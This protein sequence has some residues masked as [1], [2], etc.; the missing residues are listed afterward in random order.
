MRVARLHGAGDLRVGDEPAP[1]SDAVRSY[2]AGTADDHCRVRILSAGLC[3]SDLHWFTEGA[4]G[5]AVLAR[6]LVPGHELSGLVLDG[7]LAGAVVGI[8][9]AVPC[10]QC[11]VCRRGAG[12][13]CPDVAFAGHGGVDGGLQE[14]LVWPLAQLHRL[15]DGFGAAEGAL[16]EPLGVAVHALDLSHL[17]A[18]CGVGVIGC[19]PIGLMLVQLAVAAGAQVA[20]VEPLAHRREAARRAGAVVVLQPQ[21]LSR[22][23][24]DGCEVVFEVSG[25]DGGVAAAGALVAPGGRIVLVGIPDG[26]RTTLRASP[27]R[28]KGA[29]LAFVRRMTEDAYRRG[30]GLA[31]DRVVDLSWLT[32]HRFPLEQAAEAFAVAVAREGLK[33]VVDVTPSGLAAGAMPVIG[34]SE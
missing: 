26:D 25:S 19:G 1:C 28:R 11:P 7:P 34:R 30:I 4:I 13:L 12:H 21:E 29:T 22:G 17:R 27:F 31:G 15:P 10:G 9:P 23:P 33:V 14:E 2:P 24:L 8:D 6:P 18:G 16:L 32:T 5:D 20:A 3:G